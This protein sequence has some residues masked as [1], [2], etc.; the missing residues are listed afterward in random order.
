MTQHTNTENLEIYYSVSD[1]IRVTKSVNPLTKL[2]EV[3]QKGIPCSYTA[4]LKH[5]T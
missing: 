2:V 4:Y 1:M 3:K 5:Y